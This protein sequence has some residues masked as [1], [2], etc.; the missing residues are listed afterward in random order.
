MVINEAELKH[1]VKRII[2]LTLENSQAAKQEVLVVVSGTSASHIEAALKAFQPRANEVVTAVVS[3]EVMQNEQL[4]RL[5]CAK[6]QK[7]VSPQ[8]LADGALNFNKV[9]F[10]TMPRSILAKCA[11]CIADAYEVKLVQSAFE[12]NVPV[13]LAKGA[14][15]KFSGNEPKA[16]QQKILGYVRDLLEFGINI[17]LDA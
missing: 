6:F 16:Y 15:Q 12:Q 7:I 4:G 14:L 10:L 2:E 8:T 13:V 5:I 1:L 9:V 17:E 11:L 3:N